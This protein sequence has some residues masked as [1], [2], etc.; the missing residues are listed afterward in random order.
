MAQAKFCSYCGQRL[1]IPCPSC[2]TLNAPD[3]LFCHNCGESLVGERTPLER[4]A[5]T[6]VHPCLAAPGCP[7]C[8]AVNEPASTYCYQCGLP[9]EN[10]VSDRTPTYADAKSYQAVDYR[11]PLWR[12]AAMSVLS[13]G[14]YTFYWFYL[15]WKHYRESTGDEAYPVW[16]ALTLFVP[17][18]AFFRTHA[19]MR[20]Y[21]ELMASK[22]MPSTISPWWITASV[23]TLVLLSSIGDAWGPGRMISAVFLASDAFGKAWES[24]ATPSEAQM[25]L[26]FSVAS[27]AIVTGLLHVQSTLNRYWSRAFRSVDSPGFS[28]LEMI[29]VIIGL[30]FWFDIIAQAVSESY[31]LGL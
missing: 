22:G 19:H 6:A 18:Y 27:V 12:V 10:S 8:S 15:T 29:F 30:F 7:R 9:L 4:P 2:E 23:L 20:V 13:A 16:H 5:E 28:I 11:V 24:P 25:G 26:F 1:A 14:F 17:I 31:R 21:R 3:A